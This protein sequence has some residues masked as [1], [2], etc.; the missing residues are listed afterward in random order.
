MDTLWEKEEQNRYTLKDI[1]KRKKRNK[2]IMI[3]IKT[4]PVDNEGKARKSR[5]K[6]QRHLCPREEPGDAGNQYSS[7]THL[8][9]RTGN[10][11]SLIGVGEDVAEATDPPVCLEGQESLG[12]Q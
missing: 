6:S 2:K 9:T 7:I 4:K 8:L 3:I 1:S 10:Y 5:K 11:V 12:L